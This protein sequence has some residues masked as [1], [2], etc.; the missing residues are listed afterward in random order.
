MIE[1]ITAEVIHSV[2][3]AI[4]EYVFGKAADYYADKFWIKRKIKKILSEDKKFI[5]E[6][7]DGQKN[8]DLDV[9]TFLFND[10]FQD[11]LF[12][13][14][15]SN[16][17]EDRAKLLWERFCGYLKNKQ[18]FAGE[19]VSSLESE[20][21]IKLELC[22]NK[23][24]ELVSK[25]ILNEN[26]RII[27]KTMH[28]NQLDIMGYIGKTLDSNSELQIENH[29]LD[30]AHKQLEGILHALRMDMR[31]YKFLLMVYSIG[32]LML[33]INFVLILPEIMKVGRNQISVIC[34]F[35]LLFLLLLIPFVSAMKNVHNCENKISD[36][37]SILWELH[38]KSYKKQYEHLYEQKTKKNK[39]FT[40]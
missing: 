39:E 25:N 13:Y 31:H 36:Y 3:S 37:M 2:G 34:I 14:P 28:R 10:I 40:V 21:K 35:V 9:H 18:S 11:S 33:G 6:L 27:L 12:L 32:F 23:H 7:F 19:D 24:N 17:P 15:I 4:A 26:E 16:I 20:F 1:L 30:Y 38:F 22:V 5:D 29:K 8:M